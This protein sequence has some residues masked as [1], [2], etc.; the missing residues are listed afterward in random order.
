MPRISKQQQ[1]NGGE[2]AADW[3][4]KAYGDANQ[5]Q[6]VSP[7]DNTIAVNTPAPCGAAAP[8]KGGAAR[9][10]LQE[11]LNNKMQEM[12]QQQQENSQEGGFMQQLVDLASL[13]NKD[14]LSNKDMNQAIAMTG[15]AGVLE[16]IAVPAIL[17]YL[18]QRIGKKSSSSKNHKSM[19]LRKSSRAS[20]RYRK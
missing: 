18:N 3:A 17:L 12:Q 11:L 4:L 1:Q 13:L 9:K 14:K 10:A 8:M 6:A 20:R 7:T 19:K 15:G 5:Q 2:G 16:N